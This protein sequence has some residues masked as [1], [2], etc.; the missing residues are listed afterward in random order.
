ML[1][2]L[3]LLVFLAAT[4]CC[5]LSGYPVAFGLG[6][7]GVLFIGGLVLLSAVGTPLETTACW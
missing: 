3:I 2:L 7:V 6:G 4:F 1:E 5:L